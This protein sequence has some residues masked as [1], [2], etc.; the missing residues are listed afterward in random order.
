MRWRNSDTANRTAERR[1]RENEA[2]RLIAKVPL[3]ETLRL[4]L[5]E[6]S[7]SI[8]RPEHTHVRHVVVP[9]APALF[10]IPCHD[11][12]CRDGGH[13]LT[14]EVM[15]ALQSGKERFE[16]EDGCHGVVGS[17]ACSR[18]LSYVGLAVYRKAVPL[19]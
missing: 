15:A 6:R 3:L 9:T 4:E 5:S 7:S 8:A 14:S 12:Q 19:V 13:E 16:G 17:A 11:T 2:P 18:V 1:R 10:F